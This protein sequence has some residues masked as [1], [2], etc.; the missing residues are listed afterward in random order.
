MR[1]YCSILL[2]F[3]VLPGCG[4]AVTGSSSHV[5]GNYDIDNPLDVTVDLGVLRQGESR[6]YRCWLRNPTD[7]PLEIKRFTSSCECLIV[8]SDT[9]CVAPG[10]RALL[11][12]LFD[13]THDAD[14]TGSLAVKVG[15]VGPNEELIGQITADVEVAG[16][17]EAVGARVGTRVSRPSVVISAKAGSLGPFPL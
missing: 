6:E 9:Q 10:K 5:S 3:L 1:C 8:S 14:F 12:I 11:T 4:S 13:G 2:G 15:V 7:R 17:G 16:T